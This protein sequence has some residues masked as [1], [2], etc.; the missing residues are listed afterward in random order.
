MT[1]LTTGPISLE[2]SLSLV[3]D[4]NF[5]SG[6]L[7]DKNAGQAFTHIVAGGFHFGFF[8]HFVGFDIVVDGA[9]HHLA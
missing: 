8:S 6:S 3:C 4:E 9:G 5:G 7:T 1:S 2:T